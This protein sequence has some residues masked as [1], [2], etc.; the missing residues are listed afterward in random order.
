VSVDLVYDG[1]RMG[2]TIALEKAWQD[3]YRKRGP[4]TIG[5][6]CKKCGKFS[7]FM[8]KGE[9]ISELKCLHCFTI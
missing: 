7:E 4:F 9:L 1:R 6:F 8:Y 3:L 5:Y 2:K